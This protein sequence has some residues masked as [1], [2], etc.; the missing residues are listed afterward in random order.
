MQSQ[1]GVTKSMGLQQK[2]LLVNFIK[3]LN[4]VHDYD[5]SL[6]SLVQGV[7]QV[8]RELD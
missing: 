5:T 4:E 1:L 7:M 3:C 2:P 8:L 6:S